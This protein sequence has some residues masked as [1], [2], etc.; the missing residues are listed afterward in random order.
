MRVVAVFSIKGGVGKTATAVN[1][2][3]AATQELGRVLLWDLDPQGASTFYFRVRPKV[4]GGISR[5]LRRKRALDRYVRG[6]D[7]PNLDLVPADASYRYAD[8]VLDELKKPTRG[9]KRVLR[10]LREQYDTVLLDCPPSVSLLSESIFR[11]AEALVVPIVPTTLSLLTLEQL[12]GY[13]AERRSE[14]MAILPFFSMV[15]RR[16]GLHR[17]IV[18]RLPDERPEMLATRIPYSSLVEQMGIHLAPLGVFAPNSSV[19]RTY[20]ELWR[21]IRTRLGDTVAPG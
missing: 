7:Y 3:Y 11:A 21:E 17:T 6:T 14:G 4:K 9:L 2:A 18:Q 1:L 12:D 5:L 13:C 20:G 16:K 19:T 10:P 15:D 8:L